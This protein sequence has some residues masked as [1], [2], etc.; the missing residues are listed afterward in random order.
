MK[1]I[2]FR[3]EGTFEAMRAAEAWLDARGFSVGP[4][5]VCAPRAIWHGDCW[6]SKW[7][8]LSPKER[9]QAHALMEGDGRNGPVWITLTKAATEEARAAFISE[10]AATQTTEG[11][12]NG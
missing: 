3:N 4:S 9:A 5:Q 10:P 6:I 7:R 12:G 11:A 1:M 8:N 2:E